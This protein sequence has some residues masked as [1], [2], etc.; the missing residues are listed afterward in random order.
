M[1][2]EN[3]NSGRSYRRKVRNVFIHKPM[4]REFVFVIISLMIVSSLVIGFLIHHTI[5]DASSGGGFR[6]GNVSPYEV[7]SDVSDDLM[8]RVTL[9]LFATFS[10]L[11]V[12][13]VF[14][15]HRVAGPVHRIRFILLRLNDGELPPP[16][17]L[18]EGDFFTEMADEINRLVNRI[19]FERERMDQVKKKLDQL[20]SASPADA[21]RFASEIRKL[22]NQEPLEKAE[23]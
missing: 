5:H 23:G 7:L 11:A 16:V 12:F 10:V 17:R 20:A 22:L 6:F 14:F 8:I 1:A 21:A 9:A 19:K 13:S 18:R 15:L 2:Q 4:Q 3:Q